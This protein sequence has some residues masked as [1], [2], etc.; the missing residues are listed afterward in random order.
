MRYR[1]DERRDVLRRRFFDINSAY[2]TVGRETYV[3]ISPP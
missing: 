3:G 2:E 1:H